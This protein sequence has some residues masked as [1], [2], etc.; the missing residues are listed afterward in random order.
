[1][2]TKQDLM[3]LG[4]EINL[5]PDQTGT[6]YWRYGQ[7]GSDTS[8]QE[9]VGAVQDADEHAEAVLDLHRCDNCGKVHLDEKLQDVRHAAQRVDPGCPAPSGQCP[10]CGALCYPLELDPDWEVVMAFFGLDTSFWWTGAQ[11]RDYTAR[12]VG[13]AQ[14]AR[15]EESKRTSP[16]RSNTDAPAAATE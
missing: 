8:F 14:A 4:Y 15:L 6:F 9:E 1:M 12:Y 3:A 13:A 10:D 11:R 16:D 2:L 5:D 7:D